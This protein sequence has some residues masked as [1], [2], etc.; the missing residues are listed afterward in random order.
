MKRKFL[1]YF[2]TYLFILYLP[3]LFSNLRL[4]TFEWKGDRWMMNWKGCGTKR[5]WPDLSS[6]LGNFW[7]NWGNP[8]EETCQNSRSP[9]QYLNP[10]P[11]KYEAEMLTTQPRRSLLN[12]RLTQK[13]HVRLNSNIT[14]QR[15]LDKA[16][17]TLNMSLF[18]TIAFNLIT[19]LV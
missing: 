14:I 15:S 10:G 7:R 17:D 9:V 13:Y 3:M 5:R 16:S 4:Y 2:F 6:Y 8:R 19:Q 12:V 1:Y 11:P 18:S